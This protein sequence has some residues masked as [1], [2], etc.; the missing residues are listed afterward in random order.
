MLSLRRRPAFKLVL[1]IGFDIAVADSAVISVVR[2]A[3]LPA[4]LAADACDRASQGAADRGEY[5][6][7]AGA[8]A[9]IK[10]PDSRRGQAQEH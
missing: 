5:R 6:Q 4:V 7:A 3:R 8:G 10:S 9:Q 2:P 1:F